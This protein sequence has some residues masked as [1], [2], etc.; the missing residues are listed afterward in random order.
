MDLPFLAGDPPTN[1]GSGEKLKAAFGMGGMFLN[2]E[3]F[4]CFQAYPHLS[5]LLPCGE[6][7]GEGGLLSPNAPPSNSTEASGSIWFC[8]YAGKLRAPRTHDAL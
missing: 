8:W 3:D 5:P 2:G 7:G 1:P 4:T 6:G